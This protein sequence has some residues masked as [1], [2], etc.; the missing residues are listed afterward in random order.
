MT[1]SDTTNK[2]STCQTYVIPNQISKQATDKSKS[3]NITFGTMYSLTQAE[4]DILLWHKILGQ[5]SMGNIKLLA[6]ILLMPV[7]HIANTN[8][9]QSSKAVHTENPDKT[10]KTLN[11]FHPYE[12]PIYALDNTIQAGKYSQNGKPKADKQSISANQNTTHNLYTGFL[13]KSTKYI[14]KQYHLAFD[15]TFSTTDLTSKNVTDASLNELLK[16][17]WKADFHKY[18]LHNASFFTNK[19]IT[20]ASLNELLKT[21][22]K[23]DFHKYPLHNA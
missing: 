19:N 14:R 12:C 21:A 23:A 4:H 11:I 5:L 17:A 18:P 13:D 1:P 15:D 10:K 9:K 20:D 2:H 22:W 6:H 16:T 8:T 3:M 7:N